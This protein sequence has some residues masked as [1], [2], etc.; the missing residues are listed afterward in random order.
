MFHLEY[1]NTQNF[2]RATEK[3]VAFVDVVDYH[4]DEAN[5]AYRNKYGQYGPRF[6]DLTE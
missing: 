2:S 5:G 6:V 1:A 3:G 4:P